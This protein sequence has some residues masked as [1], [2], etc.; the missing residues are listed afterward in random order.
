M[1][2]FSWLRGQ[3]LVKC[4]AEK[5]APKV[6]SF[7]TSGGAKRYLIRYYNLLIVFIISVIVEE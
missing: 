4:S 1:I 7:Q 3:N 2:V 6:F 5:K